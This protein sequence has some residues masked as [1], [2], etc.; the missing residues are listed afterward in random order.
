[1][2]REDFFDDTLPMVIKGT[3][4]DLSAKEGPNGAPT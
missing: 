1:M 2:N 4:T 3:F